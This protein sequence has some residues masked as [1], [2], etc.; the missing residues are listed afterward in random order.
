MN[1]ARIPLHGSGQSLYVAEIWVKRRDI[2][3]LAGVRLPDSL[4]SVAY[5]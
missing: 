1:E 3:P 4:Y 5:F 2:M